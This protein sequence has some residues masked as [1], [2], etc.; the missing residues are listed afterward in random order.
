MSENTQT[1]AQTQQNVNLTLTLSLQD[2]NVI[3]AALQEIPF[4]AADPVIK[5]LVP[6]AQQQ[7]QQTQAQQD[8]ES[9]PQS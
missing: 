4:K 7:L 2:V 9:L 6:Q 8:A 3:I 5:R 1:A